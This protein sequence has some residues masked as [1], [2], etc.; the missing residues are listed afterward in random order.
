MSERKL[1]DPG[2]LLV[3]AGEDMELARY[4]EDQ[5]TSHLLSNFLVEVN[6]NWVDVTKLGR[7]QH[8]LHVNKYLLFARVRQQKYLF[9][10]FLDFCPRL[11]DLTLTFA[12]REKAK[13]SRSEPRAYV[14]FI[15]SLHGASSELP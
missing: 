11:H 14:V 1:K 13:R 4:S 5:T 2:S 7:G 10:V 8:E 3:T 6:A 9:I 12:P 15:F